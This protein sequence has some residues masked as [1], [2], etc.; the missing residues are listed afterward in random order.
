M[1]GSR[2]RGTAEGQKPETSSEKCNCTSS[3]PTLP[4]LRAM[5]ARG[6]KTERSKGRG[7]VASPKKPYCSLDLRQLVQL[8]SQRGAVENLDACGS[9]VR[10]HVPT[11][12]HNREDDASIQQIPR[13]RKPSTG[14][15]VFQAIST[16]LTPRVELAKSRGIV[17][18][19]GG[20]NTTP[21]AKKQPT[22]RQ[23][24]QS[25]ASE[26][27]HLSPPIPMK[28]LFTLQT[29]KL[30]KTPHQKTPASELGRN[31]QSTEKP[32]H[33]QE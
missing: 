7:G 12:T 30:R 9:G 2:R 31:K 5:W 13:T 1:L 25:I 14:M 20:L 4:P 23:G 33:A 10:G 27:E 24:A 21:Q 3:T 16:P 32:R 17:K 6:R 29:E 11:H 18:T 15:V 19:P 22:D 8:H 28:V 26:K